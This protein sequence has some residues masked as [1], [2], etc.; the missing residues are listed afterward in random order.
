M[1]RLH[2]GPHHEHP[3]QGLGAPA[4]QGQPDAHQAAPDRGH[5]VDE[6]DGLVSEGSEGEGALDQARRGEED[7]PPGQGAEGLEAE[8]L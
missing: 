2:P 4:T 5:T 7:G 6:G 8:G 1:P 3:G